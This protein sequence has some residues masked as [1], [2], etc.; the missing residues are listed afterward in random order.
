MSKVQNPSKI[1]IR[2]MEEGAVEEKY[3]AESSVSRDSSGG[4]VLWKPWKEAS[5]RG[6][7]VHSDDA[8]SGQRKSEKQPLSLKTG[9][10]W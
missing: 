7:K 2:S 8:T 6:G 9:S 1:N 10:Y 4:S 3:S 5:S